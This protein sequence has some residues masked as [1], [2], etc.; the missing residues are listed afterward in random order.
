MKRIGVSCVVIGA[1]RC[2]SPGT[3]WAAFEQEGQ[4]YPTGS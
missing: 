2:C 4:P 3:A 1:L